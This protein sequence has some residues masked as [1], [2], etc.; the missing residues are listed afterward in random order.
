[1]LSSSPSRQPS[2]SDMRAL[3]RLTERTPLVSGLDT[4]ETSSEAPGLES[5]EQLLA[6]RLTCLLKLL[7]LTG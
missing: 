2:L 3:P 1:M 7:M 4:V 5:E 6:S